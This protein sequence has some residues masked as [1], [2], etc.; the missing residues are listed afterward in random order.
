MAVRFLNK[1]QLEQRLL[2]ITDQWLREIDYAN[3]IQSNLVLGPIVRTEFLSGTT[4][5]FENS[6]GI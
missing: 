5:V 1:F 2:G 3:I 6:S 4:E